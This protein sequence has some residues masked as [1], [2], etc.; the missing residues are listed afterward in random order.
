MDG[1]FPDIDRNSA[2]RELNRVAIGRKN[3]LF[4]GSE[5]GGDT[6]TVL[7]S[8]T[9]TCMRLRIEDLVYLQEK[10]T[11]L[12]TTPPQRLRDLLPDR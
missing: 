5:R 3:W 2:E 10:L 12:P 4:L 1:W 9:A 8:F 6:A 7:L 11:R